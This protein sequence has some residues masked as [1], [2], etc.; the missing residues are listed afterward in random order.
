MLSLTVILCNQLS[1]HARIILPFARAHDAGLVRARPLRSVLVN[2][3]FVETSHEKFS[4]DLW[5][6]FAFAEVAQ[7]AGHQ[8]E[9]VAGV[10]GKAVGRSA[11]LEIKKAQLSPKDYFS[12]K[13]KSTTFFH[14][15]IS[16]SVTG[17]VSDF[18]ATR[19]RVEGVGSPRVA[20]KVTHEAPTASG[21][22]EVE[23]STLFLVKMGFSLLN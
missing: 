10:A 4:L 12:D 17:Q 19:V 2:V 9:L 13:K 6:L 21:I 16:R 8:L 20:E 11:N 18:S 3:S 7:V 23:K 5:S 22:R 1:Y 14:A 15:R